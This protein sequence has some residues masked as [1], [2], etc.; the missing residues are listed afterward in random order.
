MAPVNNESERVVKEY[1]S[2]TRAFADGKPVHLNCSVAILHQGLPQTADEMLDLET[3]HQVLARYSYLVFVFVF[4]FLF[5]RQILDN[6]LWLSQRFSEYFC[7]AEK[8]LIE[9]QRCT[10]LIEEAL[11][12]GFKVSTK[13]AEAKIKN[14]SSNEDAVE[15]DYSF[16]RQ[17]KSLNGFEKRLQ[18]NKRQKRVIQ[19]RKY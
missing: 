13:T 4:E 14:A 8:A 10:V 5:I 12:A 16:E 17:S 11:K 19:S 2:W 1:K 15:V 6:Y 3:T 18:N 7:D 9:C